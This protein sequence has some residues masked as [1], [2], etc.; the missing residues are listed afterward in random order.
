MVDAII[1]DGRRQSEVMLGEQDQHYALGFL[2]KAFG[3]WYTNAEVL[4]G[5]TQWMSP[6][7]RL[8]SHFGPFEVLTAYTP[9]HSHPTTMTYRSQI[10]GQYWPT[11]FSKDVSSV[12]EGADSV[13]YESTDIVVDP[14]DTSSLK[15]FQ[16]RIEQGEGPFY[17]NPQEIRTQ[18][19]GAPLKIYRLGCK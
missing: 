15:A 1:L 5:M 9:I 8:H 3:L 17:L 19:L 7:L 6:S 16:R 12:M 2:S 13:Q 10:R 14:K 4:C 11:F 18:A